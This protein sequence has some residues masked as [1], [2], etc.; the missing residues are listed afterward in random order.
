[1]K[2]QL[3][4]GVTEDTVIYRVFP[5]WRALQLVQTHALA[6]V[7]PRM[8]DDPFENI[9]M[10]GTVVT[11][12]GP[13]SIESTRDSW[14]GQCWTTTS[15]S[16]AMWRIYSGEKTG[17]RVA[18][19]VGKLFAAVCPKPDDWTWMT[20]FIG[21]VEY[22][23]EREIEDMIG[24]MTFSGLAMGGGNERFAQTLLFKRDAFRHEQEVRVLFNDV[25][26]AISDPV[27]LF[28]FAP[29]SLID[30]LMLDPRLDDWMVASM[31]SAFNAAGFAG[32]ICRSAL[33]RVPDIS[34]PL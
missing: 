20:H 27:A 21:R 5:F 31:T 30:D 34:I 19:T 26:K 6:L 18:T 29:G 12:T 4:N 32:P 13:A 2:D 11:P 22:L 7:R 24:G 3:L 14:Y 25:H 28:Q 9:V 1:M 17:V 16:D 15:E 10:S 23:S 33:Y 8:W